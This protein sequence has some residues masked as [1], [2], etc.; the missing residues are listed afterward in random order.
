[1]RGRSMRRAG[2][3]AIVA[4]TLGTV[5]LLLPGAASAQTLSPSHYGELD[6]NGDSPIQ[7]AV[8]LTGF[9]TDIRGFDN[10]W[11]ANTWDGRFYDNGQY[12]GHDEPDMTFLSNRAGSGNNV[13]WSETLGADPAAAPTIATPGS[14]V[15]H[16]FELSPAPW[17]SMAICD[18]RSYPQTPCV[19]ESDV[20]HPQCGVAV[21]GGPPCPATASGGGGSAFME[22]QFYPP[23][24]APPWVGVSCD[25][26]HWCA[27]LTIDSL[28]CTLGFATCNNNCIEP[29]NFGLI[30]TDG[31]PAGPPNPQEFNASTVTPNSHTLLM[32]QGDHLTVH[33]YDAP[34][35][36]EPGQRALKAVVTDLTTGQTGWMQASAKNGFADTSMA[37]CSGHPHNF[38]P[39][40]NTAKPSNIVPWAALQ[41]NISTQYETGHFEGCTSL[42]RRDTFPLP[43][44]P[45][46]VTLTT[47]LTCNGPY[48]STTS[49]D[50]SNGLE[51]TDAPC[52]PK[53]WTNAPDFHTAPIVVTGCLDEL[54]QNGDLDFDGSP[55]WPEWPTS[56]T[57]N[58]YPGSF[59]QLRPTTNGAAY[60]EFFIQTDLALS[61]STCT[62]TGAGCT[63]PPP[64]PGNFYP[65]WTRAGGS[66]EQS[67]QIEF[68]NVSSGAT[69]G[70]DAQYGTDQQ[71][72]AG[73]P[74]FEGPIMKNSV[75]Q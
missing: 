63:I 37:D 23:G 35:P 6:C 42:S 25:D 54:T 52:Y 65:Y 58:K 75:C 43:P 20:N 31:V 40:Y 51:P 53:G 30:S 49:S 62:A 74:E 60:S 15:S 41:T 13:T 38:Q 44:P 70:K 16:W 12:I 8:K 10:V 11:N 27:A 46:G 45:H 22:L 64:G 36:G 59:Q 48:E 50:Q 68:G 2:L 4:A 18:S 28:E 72:S 32:N 26:S 69:F 56:T 24:F 33:V 73:Y 47:W 71:P 57:P 29:V 1:M 19:P 9:C 3:L 39:E 67:C 7:Q 55:Y 14:D 21:A 5:S 61:E 66:S 34:V 17:F